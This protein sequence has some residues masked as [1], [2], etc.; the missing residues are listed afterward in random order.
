MVFSQDIKAKDAEIDKLKAELGA[1][2]VA[3]KESVQLASKVKTL[4]KD[5]KKMSDDNKT[6]ADSFN[7]ERVRYT[8]ELSRQQF[9]P[10]F[11]KGN[12]L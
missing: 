9:G 1:L 2:G 7:S 5:A 6:L 11:N 3:A 10:R 12:N 8:K 4:E